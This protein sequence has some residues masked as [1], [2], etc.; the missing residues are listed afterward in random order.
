MHPWRYDVSWRI[1][2][3]PPQSS[4]PLGASTNNEVDASR[5]PM[6]TRDET[7]HRRRQRGRGNGRRRRT[8]ARSRRHLNF[9][10]VTPTRSNCVF[11]MCVPTVCSN[12][13]FQLCVP[14]V[15]SNRV[16]MSC[17]V[18]VCALN[19]LGISTQWSVFSTRTPT[20]AQTHIRMGQAAGW[21]SVSILRGIY[22]QFAKTTTALHR[23]PHRECR[24]PL[25]TRAMAKSEHGRGTY[26]FLEVA[27]HVR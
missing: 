22:Q 17:R 6:H 25:R 23:H 12:C 13:V 15:C 18:G 24:L 14:T 10:S 26:F 1:I 4:L 5:R 7:S 27:R 21:F 11:R 16:L 8:E 19:N 9:T 20:H 2:G 3:L